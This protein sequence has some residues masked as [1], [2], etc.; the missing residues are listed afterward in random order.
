M[1]P[2]ASA[3]LSPALSRE[4]ESW[5]IQSTLAGRP[6]AFGDLVQPHLPSISRLARARVQNDSEAEDVVQQALLKALLHLGQ[7]RG[8]ASFRTWLSAIAINETG[9]FRRAASAVASVRPLPDGRAEKLA[10]PSGSPETRFQRDQEI[11]RLRQAVRRLPEK[12]RLMIQ[13]RD[14][15]ELNVAETARRLS[16]TVAAVRTRHHRARKL[17]VRSLDCARATA[18][19]VRP[20]GLSIRGR[21]G[22]SRQVIATPCE[23]GFDNGPDNKEDTHESR[24]H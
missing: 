18:Q 7:F 24:R 16:I 1:L 9:H 19:V 17:L 22:D 21:S 5:L 15:R 2:C 12:Y 14:L 10:D 6:E 4:G 3:T 13:L 11:E 20:L 23:T 8:E